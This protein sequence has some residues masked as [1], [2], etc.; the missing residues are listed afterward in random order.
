MLV[1]PSLRDQVDAATSSLSISPPSIS[2][3]AAMAAFEPETRAICAGLVA[4]YASNR[5]VVLDALAAIGVAVAP[6]CGSFY[7]YAD[8]SP[9][10]DDTTEF[11]HRLLDETGVALVP[12]AEFDTLA[13][14]TWAR[15][16]FSGTSAEVTAGADALVTR[17][18]QRV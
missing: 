2:Q 10:T 6:S 8:F 4:G 9:F 3:F 13:G 14:H 17:L 16:S 5:A 11:C 18:Q 12:G 1:P 15:L 7:L